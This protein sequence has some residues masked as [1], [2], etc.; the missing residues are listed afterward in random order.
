M[1]CVIFL[2]ENWCHEAA[3]FFDAVVINRNINYVS[4]STAHS[5]FR[6]VFY[7][8]WTAFAEIILRI[9]NRQSD[10]LDGRSKIRLNESG[11]YF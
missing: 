5:S 1:K 2:E 7:I 9:L 3:P 4:S 8:S 10:Q 11:R 6:M